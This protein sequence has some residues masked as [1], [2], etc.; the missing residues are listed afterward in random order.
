MPV[1]IKASAIFILSCTF[2]VMPHSYQIQRWVFLHN[3]NAHQLIVSVS[4]LCL[5]RRACLFWN[6]HL[7]LDR[8]RLLYSSESA[9]H[10][11]RLS[12]LCTW[13]SLY[14]CKHHISC[15]KNHSFQRWERSCFN[16]QLV[17]LFCSEFV[18]RAATPP[19]ECL[20]REV[21]SRAADVTLLSMSLC[22]DGLKQLGCGGDEEEPLYFPQRLPQ[23]G[24]SVRDPSGGGAA[25][26][27]A[28]QWGPSAGQEHR[29]VYR[30]ARS[31]T[32]AWHTYLA[33]LHTYLALSRHFS[34]KWLTRVM[35]HVIGRQ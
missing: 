28:R 21:R 3:A 30:R 12:D 5:W 14:L 27:S 16:F 32:Y 17:L 7:W 26:R 22:A 8:G 13:Q 29:G 10:I 11:W 19:I 6:I 2:M 33:S 18:V 9:C 31:V 23:H 34:P 20:C 25:Q 1:V 24:Q 4:V 35:K 15:D